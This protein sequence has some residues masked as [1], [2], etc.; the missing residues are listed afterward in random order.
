MCVSYIQADRMQNKGALVLWEHAGGPHHIDIVPFWA[1]PEVR[2]F[3][4]V[5]M[6]FRIGRWYMRVKYNRMKI[7]GKG[8]PPEQKKY[9]KECIP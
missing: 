2:E 3:F 9:G 6:R 4:R 1:A 7:C 8:I 5:R